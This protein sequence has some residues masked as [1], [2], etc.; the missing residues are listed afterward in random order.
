MIVALLQDTDY[1]SLVT[2]YFKLQ[3]DQH[4]VISM[5]ELGTLFDNSFLV[6]IV[7]CNETSTDFMQHLAN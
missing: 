3:D 4:T 6:R 5:K 1:K 2:S 7:C